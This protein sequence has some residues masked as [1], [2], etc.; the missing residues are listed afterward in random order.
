MSPCESE[1]TILSAPASAAPA[2]AA[3][4]SWV[5]SWRAQA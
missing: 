5:M 3:F 2:I 4:A 1:T